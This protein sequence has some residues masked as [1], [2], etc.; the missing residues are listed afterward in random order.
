MN[1]GAASDEVLA[2]AWGCRDLWGINHQWVASSFRHR[3]CILILTLH[4]VTGYGAQ[5]GKGTYTSPASLAIRWNPTPAPEDPMPKGKPLKKVTHEQ[6]PAKLS[7]AKSCWKDPIGIWWQGWAYPEPYDL[8]KQR[9]NASTFL[10]SWKWM[11]EKD[12]PPRMTIKHTDALAYFTFDWPDSSLP[13]S[14]SLP[15]KWSAEQSLPLL[16]NLGLCCTGY[17]TAQWTVAGPELRPL[18][19]DSSP[20]LGLE[21]SL[22]SPLCL[23]L[24]HPCLPRPLSTPPLKILPIL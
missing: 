14:P 10:C 20:P 17:W 18:L 5:G 6:L 1:K 21:A 24:W 11:T 8:R 12:H 4:S 16:T 9:R 23:Y 7:E 19:P 3:S 15:R 22:V 13:C 2:S